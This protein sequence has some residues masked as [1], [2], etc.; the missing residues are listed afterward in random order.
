MKNQPQEAKTPAN[1]LY[2]S[3]ELARA[4]IDSLKIV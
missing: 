3:E 4:V 2:F 1:T